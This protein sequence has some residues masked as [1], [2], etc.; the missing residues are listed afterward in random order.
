MVCSVAGD[1]LCITP[2]MLQ[3][4]YIFGAQGLVGTKRLFP[5]F[6]YL[7]EDFNGHGSARNQAAGNIGSKIK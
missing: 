3:C 4:G 5:S 2:F 6:R 7:P 1:V